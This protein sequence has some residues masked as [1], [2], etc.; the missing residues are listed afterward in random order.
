MILERV[1]VGKPRSSLPSSHLASRSGSSVDTDRSDA[2]GNAAAVAGV[3]AL[4][5]KPAEG[6]GF[7]TG[8]PFVAGTTGFEVSQAQK[9]YG[10]CLKRKVMV[11]KGFHD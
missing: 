8:W 1:L 4:L 11:I 5:L 7:V 3:T 10:M 6:G 9:K 2:D